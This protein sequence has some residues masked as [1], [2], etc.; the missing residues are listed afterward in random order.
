MTPLYTSWLGMPLTLLT[1]KRELLK[2][3][4]VPAKEVYVD[5]SLIT[6]PAEVHILDMYEMLIC[7]LAIVVRPYREPVP[8]CNHLNVANEE[9]SLGIYIT[10]E[11][12]NTDVKSA[13]Y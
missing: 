8:A 10:W 13:G 4:V 5:E 11:V 1:T 2:C 6:S 12:Q 9:P 7:L 3:S